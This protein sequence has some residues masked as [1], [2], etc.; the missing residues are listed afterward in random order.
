MADEKNIRIFVFEPTDQD[1]Q[2]VNDVLIQ[3][4]ELLT[5]NWKAWPVEKKVF[6]MD[7]LTRSFKEAYGVLSTGS[8]DID[9]KR[10]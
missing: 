10:T 1:K 5:K 6:A 3:V 8:I 7:I 2:E 9:G 4:R